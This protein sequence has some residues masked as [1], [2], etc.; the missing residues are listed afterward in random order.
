MDTLADIASMQ[1]SQIAVRQRA[2]EPATA[3]DDRKRSRPQA[4]RGNTV[5][6]IQTGNDQS[7]YHQHTRSFSHLRSGAG[8]PGERKV[9]PKVFNS[10]SV[11]A[12]DLTL[13]EELWKHLQTSPMDYRSYISLIEVLQRGLDVHMQQSDLMQSYELLADLRQARESMNQHFPV[14][15]DMWIR[16]LNEEMR[17]ATSLEERIAVVEL[18]GR[19]VSDEPS[20]PRLWRLYGDYTYSLWLAA[21]GQVSGAETWTSEEQEI[22]REVF[23]WDN[24][25]R[26]W[27]SALDH[28][29][30][31]I[32]HGNQVWDRYME[33][34]LEDLARQPTGTKTDSIQ[35]RFE[36]RL[37]K[38]PHES[39]DNTFQMFSSF[40]S[41]YKKHQYEAAMMDMSSKSAS[42]KEQYQHRD[43]FEMQIAQA[44]SA[45]DISTEWLIYSKY[46]EW[47]IT[48]K[49]VFSMP[50]IVGLY[51][52]AIT[53]FPTD[54]TI[55]LDYVEFLTQNS[56]DQGTVLGVTERATR[57][58]SWSG[59]LW[60]HRILALEDARMDFTEIE[61]VKHAAT[62]TGLLN[63]GDH[64]ELIKVYI[65]WCGCLRRRA[66]EP[67]ASDEALDIADL[68][69]TSALDYIKDMGPDGV[70]HKQKKERFVDP[71]YRLERIY[72]KFLTQRGDVAASRKQWIKLIDLHKNSYEFWYRYYIW[73]MVVW[74]KFAMRTGNEPE[75][76]LQTPRDAT[77]VLQTA[78]RYQKTIDRPDE[79]LQMFL[80]HC[81]QHESVRNFR[82]ALIEARKVSRDIIQ[83]Q[84]E[85]A[86]RAEEAAAASAA[87]SQAHLEE[88]AAISSDKRKRDDNEEENTSDNKRARTEQGS[89]LPD[90]PAVGEAPTRDREH[91]TIIV[92]GLPLDVKENRIRRFFSDVCFVLCL[93]RVI[94]TDFCIVRHN[95]SCHNPSRRRNGQRIYRVRRH[96][97]RNVRR[98]QN[99]EAIR[100][101]R[102]SGATNPRINSLRDQLPCRSRPGLPSRPLRTIWGGP[103]DS[104]A[105]IA[106]QYSASVLLHPV[107]KR[108][109]CSQ[110]PRTRWPIPLRRNQALRQDLKPRREAESPRRARRR[111]RGHCAAT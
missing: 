66:F 81:E 40:M 89:T 103:R 56:Q 59:D 107:C 28:T 43:Y 37:S 74:A 18:F 80:N 41:T 60:A 46:L 39:W 12:E 111:A 36:D 13:L 101:A 6:Q 87:L 33:I 67:G 75:D 64:E 32:R 97:R 4:R 2:S 72:I 30:S 29:K 21:N 65:A 48:T 102:Y 44:K 71:H 15:E 92:D 45:S 11:S 78:L 88:Q 110:S 3:T 55:W 85:E 10:K 94:D 7:A 83:R 61:D 98:E 69:I 42:V 14:G 9:G 47:E 19:A 54:Q 100:R 106:R 108:R 95:H 76:Q 104:S 35:Q 5:S 34:S 82:L 77:A 20:S 93:F 105:V 51:E 68:G 86:R 90:Q 25:T 73:E 53:R 24:V 49:G 63:T 22:G 23:G 91:T 27:E 8:T 38:Q 1:Q 57:H 58:C 50:L 31:D 84:A 79:L 16:W 99:I 17:V 26:T 70:G 109:I 62:A 52:R 96:A